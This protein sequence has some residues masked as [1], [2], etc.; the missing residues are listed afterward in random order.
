[1]L[2]YSSYSSVRDR[3]K[4]TGLNPNIWNNV[5][6]AAEAWDRGI[7][8]SAIRRG[9][10][11]IMR[12]GRKS[13]FWWMGAS[14]LNSKLAVKCTEHKEVT[15][16]LLRSSGVRAPENAVFGPDEAKRA[17]GWAESLAPVV[18][19]PS[20]GLMGREVHVD[21]SDW[22]SFEQAFDRV[23]ASGEMVLVERFE[24]G[25]DH[26]VLVV[27][28]KVVAVTHRIAA[29]V[30]G[31]GKS[32]VQDLV[33]VKNSKRGRSH[34]K[35]PMDD[36]AVHQLDRQK[37]TFDSVVPDGQRVFLRGNANLSAGGD[38]ADATDDLS[39]SEVELVE[40]AASAIPD[41]NVAGFDVLF[42]RESGDG[43]PNIIEV[44]SN[45][46]VSGHHFPWEGPPRDA[47]GAIL[48]A[49]FP[50]TARPIAAPRAAALTKS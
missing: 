21:I 46:G 27:G 37:L 38:I 26:R 22:K 39:L 11:I 33:L 14:S 43:E 1:M 2:T 13:H 17:W 5:V 16:Q 36:V 12:H 29:S 49:M 35:L 47:A 25:R 18:V 23:G 20:D 3:M 48:N 41:L 28:G 32:S 10:R 34:K 15:N 44:N 8:V 30:V 19:K 50:T 24:K 9:Y 45:P 42:P 4:T 6:I 40:N 31:D 7:E